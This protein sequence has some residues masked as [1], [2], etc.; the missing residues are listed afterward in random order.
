M[1]IHRQNNMHVKHFTKSSADREEKLKI[2]G[3]LCLGLLLYLKS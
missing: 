1:H 3:M 2:N